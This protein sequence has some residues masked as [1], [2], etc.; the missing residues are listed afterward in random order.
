MGIGRRWPLG[1]W[2]LPLFYGTHCPQ[3]RGHQERGIAITSRAEKKDVS[4]RMLSEASVIIPLF[5]QHQSSSSNHKPISYHGPLYCTRQQL[6]PNITPRAFIITNHQ[7]SRV[8]P[9]SLVTLTSTIT[10]AL[11]SY[12]N[13]AHHSIRAFITEDAPPLD[14]QSQPG[15]TQKKAN[16]SGQHQNFSCIST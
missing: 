5:H 14:H 9:S 15:A 1:G 7:T 3:P 11:P 8:S 12:Q 13:T 6:R 10:S 4:P 16:E 2:W